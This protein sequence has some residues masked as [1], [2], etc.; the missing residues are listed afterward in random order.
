MTQSNQDKPPAGE[1]WAINLLLPGVAFYQRRQAASTQTQTR[2]TGALVLPLVTNPASAGGTLTSS[3]VSTDVATDGNPD[4][5]DASNAS[6]SNTLDTAST[7]DEMFDAETREALTTAARIGSVFMVIG[8]IVAGVH[9]YQR[10]RGDWRYALGWG[11]AGLLA[12]LPVFGV[13][14]YQGYGK[15][16]GKGT[17]K[18]KGKA[19][20]GDS[21]DVPSKIKI[22]GLMKPRFVE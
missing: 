21:E 5:A 4:S 10:N 1:G 8:S 19:E 2:P 13:A 17:G 7:D 3:T 15:P 11:F 6:T 18:G 9:G 20:S 12:P 16:A 14:L 22:K